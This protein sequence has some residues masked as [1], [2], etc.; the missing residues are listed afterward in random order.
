MS[1]DVSMDLI[2]GM[3][4]LYAYDQADRLVADWWCLLDA[5]TSP[6]TP[7]LSLDVFTELT[8]TMQWLDPLLDPR[9]ILFGIG[10]LPKFG[11]GPHEAVALVQ[12]AIDKVDEIRHEDAKKYYRLRFGLTAA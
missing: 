3:D 5:L 12:R 8:V 2:Y 1:V 10:L 11:G 9:Q 7:S 4:L 6:G